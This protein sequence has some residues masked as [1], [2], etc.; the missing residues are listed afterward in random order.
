[1]PPPLAPSAPTQVRHLVLRA[2]CCS[3]SSEVVVTVPHRMTLKHELAR[4]RSIA[5]Q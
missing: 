2:E 1:M 4:E 5:I 3:D